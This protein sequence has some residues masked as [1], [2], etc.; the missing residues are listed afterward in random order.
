MFGK[1][2]LPLLS[3][4]W[5]LPWL[6]QNW[7]DPRAH[8]LV[9]VLNSTS[10]LLFMFAVLIYLWC[11]QCLLYPPLLVLAVANHLPVLV[12]L[13]LWAKMVIPCDT[14]HPSYDPIQTSRPL[15]SRW[16]EDIWSFQSFNDDRIRFMESYIY[17]YIYLYIYIYFMYIFKS[18]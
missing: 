3:C 12:K 18:I 1:L 6:G 8:A 10:H 16:D 11:L 15:G 4:R 5:C 9:L 13:R 14:R 17:I 2:W 7:W